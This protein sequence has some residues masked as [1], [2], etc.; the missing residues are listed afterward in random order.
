[1]K[2]TIF[3]LLLLGLL[4][5]PAAAQTIG[6]STNS[7][8]SVTLAWTDSI[9]AGVTGYNV[10]FGGS[11]GNYTNMVQVSGSS[12]TNVTVTNLVAGSSYF[13]N[14][15][16]TNSTTGLESVY[17]GEVSTVVP[18]PPAAPTGLKITATQ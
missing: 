1:M 8:P 9:S 11:T 7:V 12:A 6:R 16:S 17:A 4:A 15:T 2:K 13:F 18:S 10:Y 5:L 3:F 14:M